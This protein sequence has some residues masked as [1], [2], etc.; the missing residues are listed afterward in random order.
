MM[1]LI[2]IILVEK[3]FFRFYKNVFDAL[4]YIIQQSK[5]DET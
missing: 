1:S 4:K 2:K 5:L 3:R